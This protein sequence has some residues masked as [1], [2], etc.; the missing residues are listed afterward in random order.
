VGVHDDALAVLVRE[1]NALLDVSC[2]WMRE[3]YAQMLAV[4]A[5]PEPRAMSARM[6]Q[7]WIDAYVEG[8]IR[9][10]LPELRRQVEP[11]RA[12][13]VLRTLAGRQ[14]SELVKARLAAETSIPTGAITGYLDLLQDVGLVTTV[15]PWT[16]NLAKRET[17][18]AKACVTD[19]AVAM[20][21]TRTTPDH[22]A[23]IEYGEALGA[24]L[25]AFVTVELLRQRTWSS[26]SFDLYHYRDHDGEEI[27]LVIELDDGRIIAVEVKA[28]MSFTAKQFRGLTTLRDRLGERFVAGIVLNTS[29]TG[30]RY[31]DRLYGAPISALWTLGH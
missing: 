19:S 30:Y 23:R 18:R 11:D 20:R 7:H 9:R 4:G 25:E 3:D 10:D 26:Q 13:A 16:P 12:L 22:I 31:A 15:P 1:P 6:R 2:D 28:A 21:L 29:N 5:Y 14:S 27:D 17:G 24:L 8:V